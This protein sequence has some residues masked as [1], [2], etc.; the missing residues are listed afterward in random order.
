MPFALPLVGRLGSVIPFF[1]RHSRSAAKRLPAAPA[2]LPAAVEVVA[3]ALVLVAVDALFD[4]L[5]HAA[6]QRPASITRTTAVTM[7][8]LLRLLLLMS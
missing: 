5:P 1:C 7:V 8:T 3:L 2:G 6:R 4:E